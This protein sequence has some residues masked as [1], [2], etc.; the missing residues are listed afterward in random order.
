MSSET[1][2]RD[3]W[4]AALLQ[5]LRIAGV[6]LPNR[7]MTSALTLQ[8]G[9]HGLISD[10]HLA[11]YRER[12]LGG[13]GLM[14]SEQL[15]A[16]PLSTGPFVHAL[17]A[18]D[19]RQIPALER[20]AM[21]LKPFETKFFAQL[22]SAGAASTSSGSTMQWAPVRAPSDVPAPEGD[23]PSPLR[24]DEIQQIVRD[25]AV[26][27]GNVR[28]GL[29]H[30]VEIH[31]AHGWLVGQFLSPYY[32]R[33]VDRYGG[34]V[35][36]RC[37]LALEIGAA[38]RTEVGRHFPVGIALTYDELMGVAGITPEDT[39][40]QLQV[41]DRSGLFDF[42]DLSIG[43]SHHQHH[44]I[45]SMAVAEGFALP[46]AAR[47]RAI[48]RAETAILVA[49]RVVDPYMAG[50]AIAE[51]QA[52]VV[53]MTRAHLADPHLLRKVRAVA[54]KATVIRCIGA[55]FCVSRAL[56][57][58]PVTCVLNPVT[59][60]ELEWRTLPRSARAKK[61]AVVGAG[62]AGLRFASIAAQA[63][64]AVTLME[65]QSAAGGHLS[66]LAKLPTRENWSRAIEDMTNIA[67]A[68]GAHLQ[69]ECNVMN[70]ETLAQ[71]EVIV[72]ATGS[73]WT[74][75]SELM[76]GT[77]AEAHRD[78]NTTS[79]MTIDHAIDL[80]TQANAEQFGQHV[81]I[82]DAT[83][84]YLPLGL[85]DKLSALGI[86]ITLATPND[87]LAHIAR[88]ELEFPHVMRRLQRS[89]VDVFVA[90]KLRQIIGHDAILE[91]SWGGISRPLENIDS[92]V[93]STS[94]SAVNDLYLQ[95][96]ESRTGVH[97]L[98]D[99]VSPRST[100]AVIYEGEM[101]ARSL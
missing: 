58:E 32:N 98:G 82:I 56:A 13:I 72:V 52:D 68:S 74:I 5:P 11:F 16:S 26:S 33:R 17:S 89:G 41:L 59:G 64:H 78:I 79:F 40:A 90:H 84:T 75:P 24:N 9:S 15:V 80:S 51:R 97:C 19:P 27:A 12:A 70:K 93:F 46:F 8:Y 30:G 85:A 48:V 23:A 53:G 71:W 49:G 6:E 42:F 20:I 50:R 57:D 25:Y 87:S 2:E 65:R 39:L 4:L 36:N 37:R 38:I 88:K 101:L 61:I 92:V 83:G 96:T 35:E 81:L 55:N 94:R 28:A 45:A 95:L 63:G 62:P 10:R 86:H 54:S 14:F 29:L 1:H 100:A 7:L 67:L 31:G 76:D 34:S 66:I 69:L 18:H 77:D 60:R 47:A 22:F 91:G 21:T 73:R 99:A 3:G 44:T 43:S